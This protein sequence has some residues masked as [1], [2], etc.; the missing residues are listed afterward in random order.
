MI[1]LIHK[2]FNVIPTLYIIEKE[3]WTMVF[4]TNMDGSIYTLAVEGRIDMLNADKFQQQAD[5]A[6]AKILGK[7]GTLIIDFSG[8]KYI[9]S[10]GLRVIMSC[11]K[12]T[13]KNNCTF[14]IINVLPAIMEI[15]EITG[16][17]NI[18]DITGTEVQ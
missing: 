4:R 6:M 16:F 12:Q 13:T 10:A 1:I 9:S 17:K 7:N 18:V 8:L 2:V 11:Y 3:F 5:E 14:K 15:L